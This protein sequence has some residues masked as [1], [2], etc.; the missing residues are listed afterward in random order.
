MC[1]DETALPLLSSL[2]ETSTA[3]CEADVAE[4]LAV[5]ILYKERGEFP[6]HHQLAQL[7]RTNAQVAGQ[8]AV[9]VSQVA[10]SWR[11]TGRILKR[12]GT[13]GGKRTKSQV[14][15]KTQR[16]K[17]LHAFAQ[18]VKSLHAFF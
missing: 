5:H 3:R 11:S 16:V 7:R 1:A 15:K 6:M 17:S 4:L 13:Y 14:R 18:R 9:V 8:T 2:P 10:T 12:G